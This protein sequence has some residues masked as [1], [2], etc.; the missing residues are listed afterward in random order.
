M[1][2]SQKHVKQP[3]MKDYILVKHHDTMLQSQHSEAE[4]EESQVQ[5]QPGLYSQTCQKTKGWECALVTEYLPSM[6]N[7]GLILSTE[8]E[9]GEQEGKEKR[10]ECTFC[11]SSL[12]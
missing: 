11:V 12:K 8:R 7:L 5:G 3:S 4:R 10:K 6:C 9:M 2:T 1:D